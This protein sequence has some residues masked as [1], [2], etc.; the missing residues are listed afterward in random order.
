MREATRQTHDKPHLQPGIATLDFAVLLKGLEDAP[1]PLLVP[2]IP[3]EPPHVEEG[4]H[5]LGPQ[6]VAHTAGLH[7]IFRMEGHHFWCQACMC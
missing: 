6:L 4:F 3:R 5:N 7:V 2:H 1:R